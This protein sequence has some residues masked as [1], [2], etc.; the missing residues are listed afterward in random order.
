MIHLKKILTQILVI[1]ILII[2]TQCASSQHIDKQSPIQV[3]NP[4]YE[5]STEDKKSEFSVYIPVEKNAKVVL[6]YIYFKDKKINLKYDSKKSIYIGRYIPSKT[7]L[8]MSS[9]PKEEFGNQVPL[10]EEKLP[11]KLK[12][13]EAVIAY[14]QGD[15]Q[16]FFKLANMP[17][18]KE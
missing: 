6:D 4:Y 11:F 14:T 9:D 16:G 8:I 12:N 2:F 5:L 17:E 15:K 1:V 18:N 7:N 3:N 13:N 10:I